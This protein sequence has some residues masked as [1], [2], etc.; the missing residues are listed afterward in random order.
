MEGTADRLMLVLIVSDVALLGTRRL[1]RAIGL[2]ALQGVLVGL[3]ALAAHHG[4]LTGRT[5]LL[6][7]LGIGLR[8][9]LFPVL[10][11]FVARRAGGDRELEPYVGYGPSLLLGIAMLGGAMALGG[12]LQLPATGLPPLLVTAALFTMLTGVFLV[13]ARRRALTQCLGY[14]VLENGIYGF[15]VATVSDVP[16]LVELGA[17]LDLFLAVL[18]MGVAIYRITAEFDHMD[19]DQLDALKG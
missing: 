1:G 3:L 11:R 17:L 15:G 7:V 2:A 19:T 18:V 6:A 5:L 16:A 12:R 9:V 14:V 13:V 10:L 4:P 8:G